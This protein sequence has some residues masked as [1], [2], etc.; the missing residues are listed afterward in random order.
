[1][2][3]K[4]NYSQQTAIPFQITVHRKVKPPRMGVYKR[5]DIYLRHAEQTDTL[6]QN[7]TGHAEV[8]SQLCG[9]M[10][11]RLCWLQLGSLFELGGGCILDS[12]VWG[13]RIH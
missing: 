13:Q 10:E 7:R 4:L 6:K 11:G 3:D 9:F 12:L 2:L 1:M 8:P 5:Q